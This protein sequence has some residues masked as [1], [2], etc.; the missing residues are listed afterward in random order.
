MVV[1][2]RRIEERLA[3]VPLSVTVIGGLQ[4]DQ[5]AVTRW[6]DLNLPGINR[7]GVCSTG[8]LATTSLSTPVARGASRTGSMHKG[9][10]MPSEMTDPRQAAQHGR[11][12]R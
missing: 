3:E 9:R 1:T 6:E 11:A 8:P 5:F 4:L 10:K 2:A 12:R 7:A